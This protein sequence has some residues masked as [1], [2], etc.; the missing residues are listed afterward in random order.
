M[1]DY[2]DVG[3]DEHYYDDT[4]SNYSDDTTAAQFNATGKCIN[5]ALVTHYSLIPAFLIILILSFHRKRKTC[6]SSV[7]GGRPGFQYPVNFIDETSKRWAYAAAYG[8]LGT[9]VLGL[10]DGEYVWIP[11]AYSDP[12]FAKAY[13][14]TKV[15]ISIVNVAEF[16]IVFYPFV[17]CISARR[18]V[19]ANIFGILYP[20]MWLVVS[21]HAFVNCNPWNVDDGHGMQTFDTAMRILGEFPSFLCNVIVIFSGVLDLMNNIRRYCKHRPQGLK[22]LAKTTQFTVNMQKSNE[23]PKIKETRAIK[24]LRTLLETKQNPPTTL[25]DQIREMCTYRKVG[26]FKY[27][28]RV[29]CTMVVATVVMYKV[30]IYFIAIY[31]ELFQ[32]LNAELG[33]MKTDIALEFIGITTNIPELLRISKGE[34]YFALC[35]S[36]C[37]SLFN[38]IHMI[39]C[40]R[41]HLRWIFQGKRSW[42]VE[43]LGSPAAVVVHSLRYSGYQIAFLVWGFV[44]LFLVVFLVIFLVTYIFVI[45]W[46][47]GNTNFFIEKLYDVLPALGMTFLF[48]FVQLLLAKFLFLINRGQYLALD[49]RHAFHGMNFFFFIFNVILGFFS[50][51]KR[52]LFSIVFGIAMMGRLDRSSIMRDWE[53]FDAG[54]KAYLGMLELD[55]THNHPV[56]R[57]FIE[58]LQKEAEKTRIARRPGKNAGERVLEKK[59]P[60]NKWFLA[61]TLMWNRSLTVERMAELQRLELMSIKS[62]SRN[63]ILKETV[64]LTVLG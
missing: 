24:Y 12:V 16:S 1:G 11:E 50:C 10:F 27:S 19:I 6:C 49:N 55:A 48:Y 40:Y 35:F 13:G 61:R 60:K 45:P 20:A 37:F 32:F 7:L 42:M 52:I 56:L 43:D 30:F 23:K 53:R 34:V 59:W 21:L 44:V 39:M 22:S 18:H 57:A 46:R 62:E 33:G 31:E 38:M 28:P 36:F 63:G 47:D 8:C 15:F 2:E 9:T 41:K 3:L 25:K 5:I 29:V 26:G 58:I 51:I 4:T 54:F 14:W 17:A 64:E